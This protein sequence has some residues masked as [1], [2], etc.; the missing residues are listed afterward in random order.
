M[1]R[2]NSVCIATSYGLEGP[3]NE[4]FCTLPELPWGHQRPIYWVPGSPRVKQ[5]GR[6]FDHPPPSRAISL[7]P[8]CASSP[9]GW[10]SSLYSFFYKSTQ[11]RIPEHPNPYV[12]CLSF[13]V[14][15]SSHS[16]NCASWYICVG[17]TNKMH[18]FLM[19]NN[20]LLE[21]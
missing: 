2:G 1:C 3:G 21:T 6:G 7:M 8:F 5:S 15:H 19:M 10:R 17:T 20:Y 14:L 9:F 4:N 18:T 11:L 16:L 13:T 12:H